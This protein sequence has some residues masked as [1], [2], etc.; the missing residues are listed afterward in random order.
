[1]SQEE[2]SLLELER[3]L[4]ERNTQLEQKHKELRERAATAINFD[5]SFSDDDVDSPMDVSHEEPTPAR[6][7]STG[8]R[9]DFVRRSATSADIT[10]TQPL[11]NLPAQAALKFQNERVNVL[12]SELAIAADTLQEQQAELEGATTK[13]KELSQQNLLLT[14][15]ETQQRLHNEKLERKLS[16]MSSQLLDLQAEKAS[17]EEQHDTL[18]RE[19][20]LAKTRTGNVDV[21]LNRAYETIERLQ[22]KVTVL[23][24]NLQEE[25]RLRRE[26]VDELSRKCRDFKK[27]RDELLDGL[28]KQQQLITVLQKQK[29]HLESATLL[30]LTSSEWLKLIST[31]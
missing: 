3:E 30:E 19:G 21:Q 28:K 11:E 25:K 14:K 8:S 6:R 23:E 20:R 17:I 31:E 24:D 5:L 16:S 22:S 27:Q 9:T 1:M 4:L 29:A 7:S 12:K 10:P 13:I 26:E 2:Q 15:K 18:K